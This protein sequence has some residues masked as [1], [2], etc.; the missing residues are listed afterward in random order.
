MAGRLH[1]HKCPRCGLVEQCGSL[2][3]YRT[4]YGHERLCGGGRYCRHEREGE[5]VQLRW[6]KAREAARRREA[7]ERQG[8]LL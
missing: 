2:M 6:R 8:R 4:G 1:Q 5:A 7:Q 3:C